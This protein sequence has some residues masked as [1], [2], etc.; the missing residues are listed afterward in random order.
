MASKAKIEKFATINKA[1][2]K[3]K[4]GHSRTGACT[5]QGRCFHGTKPKLK[6]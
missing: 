2:I 5:S 1:L 4:I 3:G 6:K